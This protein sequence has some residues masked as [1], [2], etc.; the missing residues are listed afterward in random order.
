MCIIMGCSNKHSIQVLAAAQGSKFHFIA[1]LSARNIIT[2]DCFGY[3]RGETTAFRSEI[4]QGSLPSSFSFLMTASPTLKLNIPVG[5]PLYAAVCSSVSLI[6]ISVA[7]LFTAPLRVFLPQRK[8]QVQGKYGRL[9]TEYD[10]QA[11]MDGEKF[12]RQ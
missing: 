2:Q 9:R 1:T 7:P 10:Q 6:S 12:R 5:S 8:P 4:A 11:I 3:Y